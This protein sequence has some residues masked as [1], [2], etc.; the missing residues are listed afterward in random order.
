[1]LH[2][3]AAAGLTSAIIRLVNEDC[4]I[5]K[6]DGSGKTPLHHAYLNAGLDIVQILL[7]KGADVNAQ[8]GHYGNA[9]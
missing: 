8:G 3:A 1:V 2:F 4:A 5:D 7:K 9:L 6:K